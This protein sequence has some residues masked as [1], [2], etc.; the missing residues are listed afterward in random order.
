MRRVIYN[1]AAMLL[2]A[3]ALLMAGCVTDEAQEP[4]PTR[5]CELIISKSLQDIEATANAL[6]SIIACDAY[7]S[8]QSDEEREA[9]HKSLLDGFNIEPNDTG[10]TLRNRYYHNVDNEIVIEGAH[11]PLSE[12]SSWRAHRTVYRPF[13]LTI[14]ATSKGYRATISSFAVEQRSGEADLHITNTLISDDPIEVVMQLEGEIVTTDRRKSPS[15]PLTITTTITKPITLNRPSGSMR[16]G[17]FTILCVDEYYGTK[18]EI[19][20]TVDATIN[21]ITAIYEGYKMYYMF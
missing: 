13:D 3:T 10:Y 21:K 5:A 16:G 11:G 9:I 12:G 19:S 20:A 1:I 15:Q 18:D 7:L 8:A 17:K 4:M 14:E 2:S 6:Q